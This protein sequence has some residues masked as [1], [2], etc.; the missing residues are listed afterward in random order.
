VISVAL[1]DNERRNQFRVRVQCDKSP[2]IAIRASLCRILPLRTN[3]T[4][5]LIN[6]NL[7][8]FQS[9]HFLILDFGTGRADANA[10]PH[11]GIAMNASY[12][13]NGADGTAFAEQADDLRLCFGF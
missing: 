10:K 11:D 8:A 3:E 13:F 9:A 4:P 5:N 7:I 6:F 1:A 12:A 2:N